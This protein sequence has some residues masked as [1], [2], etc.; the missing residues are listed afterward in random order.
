MARIIQK[1][2]IL[3]NHQQVLLGPTWMAIDAAIFADFALGVG[4]AYVAVKKRN[5]ILALQSLIC[6]GSCAATSWLIFSTVSE[7]AGGYTKRRPLDCVE[8]A[9][10]RMIRIDQ[11]CNAYGECI[12][13]NSTLVDLWEMRQCQISLKP[14]IHGVR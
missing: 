10:G 8:V 5:W 1:A 2:T 12:K 11:L 3:M 6:F 7:S 13:Q 4:T 14:Y 9:P